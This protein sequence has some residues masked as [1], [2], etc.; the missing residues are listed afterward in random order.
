LSKATGLLPS[1]IFFEWFA[2][3][4]PGA[5][6]LEPVEAPAVTGDVKLALRVVE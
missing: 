4:S 5:T 2:M 1:P 6:V 3:S